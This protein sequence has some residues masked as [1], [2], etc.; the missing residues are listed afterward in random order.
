MINFLYFAKIYF[1]KITYINYTKK[2]YNNTPKGLGVL[3]FNNFTLEELPRDNDMEIFIPFKV[4]SKNMDFTILADSKWSEIIA[5]GNMA[6]LKKYENE[7][8]NKFSDK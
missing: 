8:N 6:D 2:F 5:N 4:K 7:F 1:Q 3:A